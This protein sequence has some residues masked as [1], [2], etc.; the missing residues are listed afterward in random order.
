[1]DEWMNGW[2][3]RWIDE[4][5]GGGSLMVLESVEGWWCKRWFDGMVWWKWWCF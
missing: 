1:M 2:M 4:Y 5:V 3:K